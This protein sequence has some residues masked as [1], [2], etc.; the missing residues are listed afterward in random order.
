MVGAAESRRNGTSIITHH[1]YTDVA[2]LLLPTQGREAV[3]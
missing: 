1:P 2:M 3:Y